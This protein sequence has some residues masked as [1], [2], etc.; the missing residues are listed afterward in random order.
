MTEPIPVRVT[1]YRCPHCARSHSAKARCREHIVRCWHNPDARGCKTCAHYTPGDSAEWD[2]GYPGSDESCGAGV[3]LSGRSACERCGGQN[4][5]YTGEVHRPR[6]AAHGRV[7]ERCPDCNGDG[8]E[9][10]PGPI[11]GCPKWESKPSEVMS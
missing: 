3:D 9:V 6:F 4:Y 8:T 1:R 2:T 11:I 7:M 10:K 5:I